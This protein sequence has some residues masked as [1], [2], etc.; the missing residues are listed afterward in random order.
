MSSTSMAVSP[1]DPIARE[2]SKSL[3]PER[4]AQAEMAGLL[5]GRKGKL[6][7][8][9][10]RDGMRLRHRYRSDHLV[11]RGIEQRDAVFAIHSDEQ[12]LVVR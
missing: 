1:T 2:I 5:R 6:A 8:R 4:S 7:V 11:G 12:K 10:D 3:R 9:L